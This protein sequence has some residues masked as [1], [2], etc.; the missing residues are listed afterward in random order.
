M[1]L[2]S[3]AWRFAMPEQEGQRSSRPVS[4]NQDA[5]VDDLRPSP[6]DPPPD[7]VELQGF[8]GRDTVDGYWRLYLSAD[9]DVYLR[10][11]DADIVA[12]RQ[13]GPEETTLDPSRVLVRAS[14]S[15]EKVETIPLKTQASFLQGAYAATVL[16]AAA[17]A[18]GPR[19]RRLRQGLG[20]GLNYP[21]SGSWVCQPQI[22]IEFQT[23]F[24]TIFCPPP[25]WV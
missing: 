11:A 16:T 23:C 12:S 8:L 10:I 13:R 3:A 15:V 18:M 20:A 22:T 21:V 7:V 24:C 6:T 2:I 4:L 9:L 25:I 5:L 1:R 19:L 14:A 17:S